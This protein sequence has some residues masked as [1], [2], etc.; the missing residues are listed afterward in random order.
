MEEKTIGSGKEKTFVS[1][2]GYAFGAAG[3]ECSWALVS[4]YLSLY[5]TDVVGLMPV[6]VSAILMIARIWDAVNDPM[7]G[8]IA[9]NSKFKVGRYRGWLLIGTP[10]LALFNC[11]TF[12]NLDI[13][14]PLKTI[15]CTVTYILCG[16]AYTVV[17]ISHGAL[18]S[19]MTTDPNER[20]VLQSWRGIGKNIVSFILNAVMMPMILFFGNGSTSSPKG[21]LFSAIVFSVICIPC[22]IMCFMTTKEVIRPVNKSSRKKENG[23]KKTWA[24]FKI[25]FSDHNT[26]YLMLAM[27]FTLV[28]ALGRM[29]ILSYYFVYVLDSPILISGALT[30]VS[31]G[32]VV[33][34]FYLPALAK[35]IDKKMV[36]VYSA[37]A[38]C[39]CSAMFFFIGEF[40]WTY[41][42]IP[43]S[44]L[45]GVT[46]VSPAD[47]IIG[48]IIDDC[49][50]RTGRRTDGVTY[51]TMSFAVKFGN[52]IGGSV[53][54]LILGMVG[55]VANT[56]M[57]KAVLTRMNAVINL[58]PIVLFV[59]GGICWKKIR[60]TNETA[61]KNEQIVK[62]MLSEQA[63]QN[64]REKEI[65]E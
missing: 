6:T 21:Y 5:Y 55:F 14:D 28:G 18:G 31:L 33:V 53:G 41:L 24:S 22:F 16:M 20:T 4:S 30:A 25:S 17:N 37:V 64:A 26:R 39:F 27:L 61:F 52:A 2:L 12:L 44:F 7:F 9:E 11:L 35:R 65:T 36:G 51:S 29:G 40:G 63:E 46:N 10:F 23:L 49:W 38:L 3:Q 47:I 45:M 43:V 56:D 1:R 58:L 50:I 19:S 32:A 15:Y 60:L 13:A 57:D 34:Y 54:I 42:V 48:D 62:K 8:S 59:A